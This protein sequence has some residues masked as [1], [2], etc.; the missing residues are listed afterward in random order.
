MVSSESAPASASASPLCAWS[1]CCILEEEEGLIMRMETGAEESSWREEDASGESE[2][3]K[4]SRERFAMF[5]H[6]TQRERG[7]MR[8]R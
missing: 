3:S 2:G 6:A 1:S 7:K 4:S 5:L 8:K